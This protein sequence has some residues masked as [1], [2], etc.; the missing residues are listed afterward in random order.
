MKLLIVE[1]NSTLRT[2]LCDKLVTCGYTI[3]AAATYQEATAFVNYGKYDLIVLDLGLPDG[4]GINLL[5]WLRTEN[6]V[7]NPC[8]ILSARDALQSKIEG[9]DAGADDYLIKPFEFAELHARIRALLRRPQAMNDK[10]IRLSNIILNQDKQQILVNETPLQLA[11]REYLLLKELIN[12]ANWV[13]IKNQ[14]ED[15]I[16]GLNEHSSPNAIE[17]LVSRIRKKLND[18]DAHCKI[19][20]IR[21]LGYKITKHQTVACN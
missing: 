3:D 1:D 10:L 9:L 12:N 17:A 20:T 18:A 2:L 15:R 16:Y 19:E 4:D 13:V 21:G 6:E 5:K 14:L 7:T 8:I 11:R